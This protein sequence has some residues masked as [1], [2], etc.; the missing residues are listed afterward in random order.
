MGGLC[1]AL[2]LRL[3][4]CAPRAHR[5]FLFWFGALPP[6]RRLSDAANASVAHRSLVTGWRYGGLQAYAAHVA[7][8]FKASGGSFFARYALRGGL[9]FGQQLQSSWRF[10]RQSLHLKCPPPWGRFC[11]GRPRLRLLAFVVR[12]GGVAYA[13]ARLARLSAPPRSGLG[14]D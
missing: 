13:G 6:R 7:P 8:Y 9:A 5:L 2:G 1:P 14:A 3:A 4:P 10:V 12:T 11:L